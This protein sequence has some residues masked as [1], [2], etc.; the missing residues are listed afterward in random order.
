MESPRDTLARARDLFGQ[1]RYDESEQA[2]ARLVAVPDFA[3]EGHYGLG[4]IRLTRGD[5][6]GA[7]QFLLRCLAS[8]PSHGN[9][10]YQLGAVAEQRGN[11]TEAIGRYRQAVTVQPGHH[12]ALLALDR[13]PGAGRPPDGTIPTPPPT[14]P[15]PPTDPPP[16]PPPPQH[17]NPERYGV[18]EYLAADTSPLSHKALDE[19]EALNTRRMPYVSAYLGSI[20]KRLVICT[21][22]LVIIKQTDNVLGHFPGHLAGSNVV[23]TVERDLGRAV[24]LACAG[25]LFIHLLRI[26]TTRITVERGRLQIETGLLFRKLKNIEL[27]RVENIALHRTLLQRL[28]GDGKFVIEVI[29]PALAT[30]KTRNNRPTH[31]TGV[32]RGARLEPFYHE[33]LNLVWH[34]RANPLVKGIIY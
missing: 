26:V 18:Y 30:K 23:Q 11:V 2:F 19:M 31:V 4:V 5:L 29:N 15:P 22:L 9:A 13:L 33:L 20:L 32:A 10:C 14:V 24:L 8:D 27:W 16:V 1:Q 17:E 34:L 7:E 12:G 6:A 28:T 3:A 25:E 21:V